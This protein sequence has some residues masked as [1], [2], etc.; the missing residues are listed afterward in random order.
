MSSSLLKSLTFLLKPQWLQLCQYR[1]FS[2]F[3][4]MT[5]PSRDNTLVQLGHDK[6]IF[7]PLIRCGPTS[8]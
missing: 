1:G 6:G 7:H 8:S 4:S 3:E 2:V 5:Y